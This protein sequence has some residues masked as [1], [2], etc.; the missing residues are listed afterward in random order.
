MT[1]PEAAPALEPAAIEVRELRFRWPGAPGDC[2]A[3][4]ALDVAR[5]ESVFILGASGSG[6]STLL[7]LLAGV[8]VPAAGEVRVLGQS[9]PA[10][11]QAGRDRWRADHIGYVFQQF[12]L[13]PYLSVLRNVLLPCRLSA[14]RAARAQA[15]GGADAGARALLQA[16]GIG[17]ALWD[18]P[19]ATLSVG[20]QQRVAA[21][22]ALIGQPE[23]VIADEPTSALDAPRR[24]EF[25]RLLLD[26]CARSGSTL[27]FVSHDERLGHR[28]HTGID[29]GSLNAAGAARAA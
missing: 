25:M 15:A 11:S 27:L 28:F 5:G 29:L 10:L 17:S 4:P 9:L 16:L 20:Q 18:R 19:A 3:I 22:R 26:A 23:L 12:N 8:L 6:K 13:L 1:R 14:R 7:S 21:A 24:D 2:L